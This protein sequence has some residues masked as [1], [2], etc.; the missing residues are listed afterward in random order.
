MKTLVAAFA[1]I[2][3]PVTLFALPNYDPFADATASG[4]TAYAT[5][6]WVS[7]NDAGTVG[8]GQKDATGAQWYHAGAVANNSPTIAAGN[9]Q[10]PGLAGA[11][12][13]KALVGNNTASD[14]ATGRYYHSTMS[15]SL[16]N[17]TGA[18]SRFYSFILQASDISG[19]GAGGGATA[20]IAGFNNSGASS[21]TTVP[22]VIGG[23][24]ILK[25]V[26]GG[27]QVGLCKNTEAPTFYTGQT[28]TTSDKVFV[29]VEYAM[30]SASTSDDVVNMWI[31]PSYT[32]FANNAN[33]PAV[34]LTTGSG[35]ADLANGASSSSLQSFLLGSKASTGLHLVDEVRVAADWAGVTPSLIT[36][37]P[38]SLT[39]DYGQP[40][41]FSV[42]APG[43]PTYQWQKNL[44]NL[45]GETASSLTLPAVAQADEGSYTVAVTLSGTSITSSVAT[46]TVNDPKVSSGP[47]PASQSVP[48]GN[49]AIISATAIGS[50]TLAYQWKKDGANVVDGTYGGAVISGASSATLTIAGVRAGGLGDSG[51]YTLSVTNGNGRGVTSSAAT[52][53]VIDPAI[54]SPPQSQTKNYNDTVTFNV[55]VSGSSPPFTYLWRKNGSPITVDG[56][57]IVQTDSATTSTLTIHNLTFADQATTPGYTVVVTDNLNQSTASSSATLTVVDPLITT[58]VS[59]VITNASATATLQVQAAGSGTLTYVWK[60]NGVAV[61]NG[62]TISG[63]ATDTLTIA[64]VTASD[65]KNYVV[66]VSGASTTQSSTGTLSVVQIIQQP[67][68]S[69]LVIITGSRAVFTAGAS[70][71]G[72]GTLT[73][74]WRKGG[75]DVTGATSTV[76]AT[77]SAQTGDSGLYSIRVFY[78]AGS[79]FIDS[80]TASLTVSSTALQLRPANLVVARVGDGAQTLR[81]AG[82]SIYLDQF[83]TSG[84]YVNTVTV[85]D[86]GSDALVARGSAGASIG[87]L[88]GMTALTLSADGQFLVLNGYQTNYDAAATVALGSGSTGDQLVLR[89]VATIDKLSQYAV[90][91]QALYPDIAANAFRCAAFD[92]VDD[93]WG[94]TGGTTIGVYYFG[95]EAA[96]GPITFNNAR[97]VNL[98]N[99][100]F[101]VCGANLGL[102]RFDGKPHPGDTWTQDIAYDVTGGSGACDFSV[103]PDGN[104]IYIADGRNWSATLANTNGGIQVYTNNGSGGYPIAR[105]LKPDPSSALGALYVTVDYSQVNPVVYATTI[106]QITN[107]LVRIVDDGSNSGAGTATVL[108]TAG[109]NQEFRGIRFGPSA[110]VLRPVLSPTLPGAGSTSVTVSWSSV[111]GVVYRLDYKDTLTAS[112]WTA[113]VTNTATNSTTSFIDTSS[114]A[115]T[116]RFYRVALP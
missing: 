65:A 66:E 12:G 83:T 49:T 29:V 67:T 38:S 88:S 111:S 46:L 15:K 16:G 110:S 99:G 2:I 14:L 105:L 70:V 39:I 57:R 116:S 97:I 48:P 106:G 17:G 45:S 82:N 4:G 50:P 113:L 42:T 95:T 41:V 89:A 101:Y 109:P 27:F 23:R 19:L 103:S 56:S 84:T 5:G 43:G 28:F 94:A 112:G 59:S 79:A 18:G 114:P 44:S 98:F 55:T 69:S 40:A 33:K 24:T 108:A 86:S 13:N 68:P 11:S 78:G 77:A 52:V 21:Q 22:T 10:Y 85:P 51:S 20:W 32:N 7:K 74:Q 3:A 93:Y 75:S 8:V 31:N 35:I 61:A 64:G 37:Q 26:T 100:K 72:T 47:S 102:Y 96:P 6:N 54:S 76:I 115:P 25:A 87:S 62:G 80:S 53:T 58:P 92:G 107:K 104:T 90:R 60:T 73:Y 9:L 81:D 71:A 34:T 1:A 91:A 63:A 30:N 36:S